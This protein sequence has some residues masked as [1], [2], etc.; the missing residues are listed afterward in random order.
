MKR[1]LSR[2]SPRRLLEN[3]P[4]TWFDKLTT[5][6]D[7]PVLREVE[8]LKANGGY[9]ENIEMIPFVLSVSIR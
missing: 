7:G 8:G 6:F 4:F 9:L 5:G 2:Q 1:L 3:P